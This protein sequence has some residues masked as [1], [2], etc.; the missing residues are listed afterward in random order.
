MYT[1]IKL[2]IIKGSKSDF[3][4][5][6]YNYAISY[7]EIKAVIQTDKFIKKL[8]GRVPRYQGLSKSKGV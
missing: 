5:S 1:S 2:I 4:Y 8:V 3:S 6:E 7:S